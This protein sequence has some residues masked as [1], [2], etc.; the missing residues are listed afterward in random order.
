MDE[1]SCENCYYRDFAL[2]DYPCS[3][4]NRN[5]PHEDMWKPHIDIV[6]CKECKWFKKWEVTGRTD[7]HC[8]YVRMTR[9]GLQ[10]INTNAD[11]FCSYGEVRDE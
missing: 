2:N 3:R 1:R 5:L 8:G 6:F 11:D 9:D 10:H 7:G 4:C